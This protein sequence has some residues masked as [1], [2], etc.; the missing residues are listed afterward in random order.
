MLIEG[1]TFDYED[2]K[3][4]GLDYSFRSLDKAID[5][6]KEKRANLFQR[7]LG[8]KNIFV[9]NDECV[10]VVKGNKDYTFALYYYEDYGKEEIDFIIELT[11]LR[12]LLHK[13]ILQ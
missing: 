6:L 5:L 9:F 8:T 4:E 1:S 13:E 12:L 2:R 3:D 11:R 7:I 10:V